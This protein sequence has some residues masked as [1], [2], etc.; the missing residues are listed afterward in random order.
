M[1]RFLKEAER[2]CRMFDT[3]LEGRDFIVDT[4]YTIIDMPGR[5][6]LTDNERDFHEI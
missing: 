4:T 3:H 5:I 2:H 6:C 1:N